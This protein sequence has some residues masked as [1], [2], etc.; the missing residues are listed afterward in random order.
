MDDGQ[1]SKEVYFTYN[2]LLFRA[3]KT[4]ASTDWFLLLCDDLLQGF[5]LAAEHLEALFVA[6][7]TSICV[8]YCIFGVGIEFC[9]SH[10][11][12]V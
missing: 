10:L 11:S 12:V 3:V 6:E 5:P 1:C 4:T 8:E 9:F 7:A 2:Y